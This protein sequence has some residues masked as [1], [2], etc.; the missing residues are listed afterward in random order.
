MF[1]FFRDNFFYD[2]EFLRLKMYQNIK[3]IST[4]Q[5]ENSSSLLLFYLFLFL[6]FFCFI[7]KGKETI[8]NKIRQISLERIQLSKFDFWNMSDRKTWTEG[9]FKN[10]KYLNRKPFCQSKQVIVNWSG[11]QSWEESK[12]IDNLMRSEW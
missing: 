8:Q 2:W 11:K 10:S 1:S 4:C 5:F 12:D 9:Q 3:E 7:W 6:V